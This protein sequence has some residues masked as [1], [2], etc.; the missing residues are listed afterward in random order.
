MIA[1]DTQAILF[2]EKIIIVVQKFSSIEEQTEIFMPDL[3]Q[4]ESSGCESP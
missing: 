1:K 3:F 2:S 4:I